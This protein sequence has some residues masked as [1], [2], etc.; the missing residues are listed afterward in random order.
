MSVIVRIPGPLRKIT[1]GADKVEVIASDLKGLIGELDNK[2]PGIKDRIL[3]ENDELRYFVN[4]YL[5]NEDVRFLDGLTTSVNAGDE[6]S[7]VPAV[8]GGF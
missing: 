1:E 3:D 5:N 4:L 7:I 6:V 8:A 2:Y